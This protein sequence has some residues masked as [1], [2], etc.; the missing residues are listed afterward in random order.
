MGNALPALAV[1]GAAKAVFAFDDASCVALGD[2]HLKCF[3]D[4]LPYPL[5]ADMVF[6]SPVKKLVL[7][8][9]GATYAMS[10]QHACALLED[11]SLRCWGSNQFGALGVPAAITSLA[12]DAALGAA[13]LA[14]IEI[15]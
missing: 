14:P 4:A 13:S 11:Q 12:Y 2:G 5:V 7:S 6:P 8:G 15:P 10:A 1:G 3:G 9:S